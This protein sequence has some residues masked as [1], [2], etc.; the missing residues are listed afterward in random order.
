MPR[1]LAH[2]ALVS[3]ALAGAITLALAAPA[4][5][6]APIQGP[7]SALSAATAALASTRYPQPQAVPYP[8][9]ISIA[10]DAT[11][12]ERKVFR[13]RE[14]LPVKPGRL[15]LLYPRWLP[16]QHGPY[17]EVERI[18]GLQVSAK[19]QMLRWE[20]DPVEPQAFHMEVPA[21]V[22]E[23]QVEYQ[24]LSPTTRDAG[25]VVMAPNMLNLQ[26]SSVVLYPAG[27][28][29][30]QIRFA[31]K[32]KLPEGWQWAG[33]LRGRGE[34]DGWVQYDPVTLD[35]LVDSPLYAGR[36]HRAVPLDTSS[37]AQPVVLHLMADEPGQLD[38][39][40]AQL[41]AHREL[42]S[43]ADRLF[44]A[45]HFRHY[46]FLLSLSDTQGGIGLEHHESS[47]NG[48]KPRYFKDWDKATGPRGLLPHEYVHSWDG[49]FRRPAD[50][51]TPDFNSVPMRN[52]L[53]W[54]YEG[55]TQYWGRVLTAR[56]GLSTL[57]QA[58][59]DL[60]RTAAWA[61][62]RAGRQ[63]RPLQDTTSEG[64][65]ALRKEDKQWTDWQRSADYYDEAALIWL[66]ADVLI[67]ERSGGTRSL[68]DF[69]RAFFGSANGPEAAGPDGR[70][71][72]QTYTFEDVVAA[73]DRVQPND[74]A[75]F[76]RT[77]L[78]RVGTPAP[79]DGL[80]RSG[81]K[82][83]YVDKAGEAVHAD[84]ERRGVDFVYSLGLRIG[85][86]E[87]ELRE[88]SWNSPAFQAGL[89]PGLKLIAVNGDAYR[90][91][92]LGEAIRANRDGKQPIELLV[93]DGER[94][95]T[96]KVDYRGGLRYPRL[97]RLP[98]VPDRLTLI[99]APK[100]G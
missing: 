28:V 24:H 97:E 84:D 64:T 98:D 9:T 3:T 45:R 23:L 86:E 34:A 67:R 16:G 18:A 37:A 33:S 70:V 2:T 7:T 90:P 29:A 30:T 91:E 39:S 77:R 99:L 27:H 11:D 22:N 63:W 40:E 60:A 57:E 17:G 13:V 42:V 32:V 56:S 87:H 14:T 1:T 93:R 53:L 46:D 10:V 65:L 25:R 75:G 15:T 41:Q 89:A 31:P 71:Q 82:L 55:Q 96:V 69:A 68:D 72:P 62:H 73:L 43:Q 100:K 76:L 20:R 35:T 74:W 47:E 92:R 80:A 58:R 83:S 95:R 85:K 8:G 49:K 48:V 81:W 44:G 50:L 59:Q 54:V 36:H 4:T 61:E 38:A 79:L 19:G 12:I 21:G 6:Q 51:W 26:W 66:E 88:V 94:Y 5:A 78:D 52:S